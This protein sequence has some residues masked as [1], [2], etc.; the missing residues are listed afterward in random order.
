[1]VDNSIDAYT[2]NNYSDKKK[3][4]LSLDSEKFEIYD[5]C[6]GIEEKTLKE[7]VFRFGV[8]E[9]VRKNP[10]LG[11]YGIGLKRSLF[12]IGKEI[13]FETDD[14]KTHSVVTLEVDEWEKN[15]DWTIP[16]KKSAS[17]LNKSEMPYTKITIKKLHED[18]SKQFSLSTFTN[19]LR[20]KI[21][22]IY[23]M[24]L[25]KK[26]DI[27]VNKSTIEGF[28][29]NIRYSDKYEPTVYKENIND[30]DV[31]IICFIQPRKKRGDPMDRTGWNF[32]CNDRLILMDNTTPETGWDGNKA[33]L[34][35]YHN[36]Y[37]EF[38]GIVRLTSN[39]PSKLP[40]NTTKTGLIYEN[41]TYKKV[42]NIMIIKSR[43]LINFLT[44]KYKNENAQLEEI[45]N[46]VEG[47]TD[48]E[49]EEDVNEVLVQDV[50]E[51]TTFSPPKPK[52]TEEK[53]SNIS[54]KKPKIIVDKLKK[55][56]KVRTNK[57]VGKKTFDYFVEMEDIDNE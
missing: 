15:D 49:V 26:V 30:V 8:T 27:I 50:E 29:L 55:Y 3:I 33:H 45:E 7:C 28:L 10:T 23:T 48:E 53:T 37:N 42:L 51:E 57:D 31:K 19:T 25:Q 5:N 16:F 20:E 54:Y 1:L 21:S 13:V 9:L 56:F 24:F 17:S 40:L 39:D 2:R 52:S 4:V 12:K 11:V 43:P 38:R 18:V 36:I 47:E 14:G 22:V 34:P 44:K 41:D 35:K 32:F 46:S 6:G